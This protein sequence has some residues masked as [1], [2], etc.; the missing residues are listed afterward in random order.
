MAM[1]LFRSVAVGYEIQLAVKII[2]LACYLYLGVKL[3]VLNRR[4]FLLAKETIPLSRFSK[5][6]KRYVI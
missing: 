1:V 4:N 6:L 3:G 2:A 5:S